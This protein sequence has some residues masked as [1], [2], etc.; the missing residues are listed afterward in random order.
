MTKLSISAALC[1]ALVLWAHSAEY[2]YEQYLNIRAAYSGQLSPDGDEVLFMSNLTGVSQAYLMPVQGGWPKQLTFFPDGADGAAFS[3]DGSLIVIVADVGGNERN[4]IYLTRPWGEAPR[5]LTFKDDVIHGFGGWSH[6]DK[7]FAY[8]SNERNSSFFDVYLYDLKRE[9]SRLLYQKDAHLVSLGWSPDDRFLIV[10]QY[11]SNYNNNLYLVNVE[12]GADRLLTQ[13]EGLALYSYVRWTP[14]SKGF[15]F[16]SDQDREFT[17]LAYYALET[18]EIQWLVTPSWDISEIALSEDGSLLAWTVNVDGNDELHLRD[19]RRNRDLPPPPLPSGIFSGFDFSADNTRLIF[20]FNSPCHT[21]DVWIY[22]LYT[23]EVQ[24]VT[25]SSLAGIDPA[26][27]VRPQLIHY[28]S[29]D[30]LEIPGFLYLPPEAKQG[31]SL[32]VLVKM[33]GGPEDQV[34]PWLSASTQ[35]F[36]HK[37]LAVFE[38]NVRGSTGYGKAYSHLDDVHKRLD[39][40][41]DMEMGARWLIEQ[42]YAHPEKLAVLGGSYGGYMVLAA[43]TEQPDLWAAGVD[44]V[45]I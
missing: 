27:L 16:L 40:V 7:Q 10:S 1:C 38:P 13:H 26:T 44:I 42:G 14:D 24:R 5:R 29:F 19:R 4:Q 11:E 3:R 35:Y 8:T 31:D 39:S 2:T 33:H 6:Y 41:K 43:L 12:T 34:R 23:N 21:S 25:Q 15:F 22:Q 17:G 18:G 37:G 36:V 9:S 32:A 45:G 30:G 28:P 20:G